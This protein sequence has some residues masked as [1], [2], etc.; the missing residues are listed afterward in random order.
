MKRRE[1]EGFTLKWESQR[2]Y[3]VVDCIE[4]AQNR[5]QVCAFFPVRQ[6]SLEFL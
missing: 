6:G 4:L 3:V 2:N 5:I 1:F